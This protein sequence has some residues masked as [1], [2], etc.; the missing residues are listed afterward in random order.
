MNGGGGARGAVPRGRKSEGWR[1]GA[2]P[3]PGA[4]TG[5]VGAMER[6]SSVGRLGGRPG[7][8]MGP[9]AAAAAAAAIVTAASAGGSMSGGVGPNGMHA[10]GHARSGS[11]G[12][13]MMGG[14]GR[15]GDSLAMDTD[16]DV[17]H[18]PLPSLDLVTGGLRNLHGGRHGGGGGGA[19]VTLCSLACILLFCCFMNGSICIPCVLV[20]HS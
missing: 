11:G 6:S 1:P 4:L 20:L 13:A 7:M 18:G 10:G 19:E 17:G 3:P 16:W 14:G 12:A 15:P 8:A 5:G 9:A 2:N